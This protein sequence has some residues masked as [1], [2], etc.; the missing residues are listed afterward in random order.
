MANDIPALQNAEAQLALLR[1]RQQTYADASRILVAQLVLTVAVPVASAVA[2]ML[3][4]QL[5]PYTAALALVIAI[6]D[7]AFLD[8]LQRQKLKLAAKIS[9]AFDEAVL[10]IPW[11]RF[12]AGRRADYETIDAAATTWRRRKGDEGLIDWYPP[13]VGQAPLHLG[14]LICQRTNLWYDATLRAHYANWVRGCAA[15]LVVALFFAALAI[16]LTV[17]LLVTTV[18]APAA[19]VLTWAMR[20]YFRQKDTADAQ[21]TLKGDAEALWERAKAGACGE[22]E[23]ET[24]SREFQNAIFTRRASSPL[25]IPVLYPWRRPAMERLMNVGAAQLLKEIGIEA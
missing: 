11:N 2:A 25:I 16:G 12:V 23:C 1:A 10:K 14:R 18:L 9:E 21:E 7:A 24:L 8:R 13:A 17:N 4:P 22:P 6:L 19:P 20:E 15:A 3:V 5:R